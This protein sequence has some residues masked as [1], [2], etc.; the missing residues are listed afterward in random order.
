MFFIYLIKCDLNKL[1]QKENWS[2]LWKI[3]VCL[4]F[5]LPIYI[6]W[7]LILYDFFHLLRNWCLKSLTLLFYNFWGN[8]KYFHMIN[9]KVASCIQRESAQLF[10][11]PVCCRATV[12]MFVLLFL[13]CISSICPQIRCRILIISLHTQSPDFAAW[14][15]FWIRHQVS[16]HQRIIYW[17][18]SKGSISLTEIKTKGMPDEFSLKCLL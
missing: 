4:F 3:T 11:H 8:F 17:Y 6:Y 1:Y 7:V 5:P 18:L 2:A 14:G 9:S 10:L 12:Y 15:S 13:I 16:S